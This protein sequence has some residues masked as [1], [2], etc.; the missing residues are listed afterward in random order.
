MASFKKPGQ[1]RVEKNQLW[2]NVQ[3]GRVGAIYRKGAGG[4]KSWLMLIG[5][6]VHHVHEGTILKFFTLVI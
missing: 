4:G 6:K 1:V 3:N 2:K 5:G